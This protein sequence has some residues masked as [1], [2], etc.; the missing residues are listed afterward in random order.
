MVNIWYELNH[1]FEVKKNI[2][3]KYNFYLMASHNFLIECIIPMF[4]LVCL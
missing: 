2:R 1:F 3:E 4:V